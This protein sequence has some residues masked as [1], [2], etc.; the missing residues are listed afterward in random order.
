MEVY[1]NEKERN[2]EYANTSARDSALALS[3]AKLILSGP[4]EDKGL[5]KA[6]P[7]KP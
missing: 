1:V 2:K 5:A 4:M 6:L 3:L 7:V